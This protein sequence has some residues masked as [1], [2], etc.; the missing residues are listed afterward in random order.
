MFALAVYF[1]YA[2]QLYVPVNIIKFYMKEF[3]PRYRLE[4]I[5]LIIRICLVMFTF[6]LGL[7]IPKLDL[8]TSLVGS[9][10]PILALVARKS[11]L[12]KSVITLVF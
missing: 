8:F 12:R 6:T 4:T 3:N 10:W 5:D 7:L 9:I 11:M 2:L 1:T